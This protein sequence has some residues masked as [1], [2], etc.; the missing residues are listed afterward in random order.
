[1]PELEEKLILGEE[2]IFVYLWIAKGKL[3]EEMKTLIGYL[4]DN[5]KVKF[6]TRIQKSIMTFFTNER[7]IFLLTKEDINSIVKAKRKTSTEGSSSSLSTVRLAEVDIDY[8]FNKFKSIYIHE[9]FSGLKILKT[10]AYKSNLVVL[11]SDCVISFLE[12]SNKKENIYQISGLK[13][14]KLNVDSG[15]HN[16]SFF[17]SQEFFFFIKNANTICSLSVNLN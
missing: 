16:D 11:R 17:F 5:H 10:H 2:K 1:M 8:R 3:L 12:V 13:D 6:Y 15:L 4:V 9:E 7:D 14:L